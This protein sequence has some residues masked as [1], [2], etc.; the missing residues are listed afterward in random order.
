ME[1]PSLLSHTDKWT[2]CITD[3]G[4]L[5]LRAPVGQILKLT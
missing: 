5:N 4:L 2:S 1:S 3:P